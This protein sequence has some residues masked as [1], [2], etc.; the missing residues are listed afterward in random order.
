MY[1]NGGRFPADDSGVVTAG[2]PRSEAAGLMILLHGRGSSPEDILSIVPWLDRQDLTFLV[3]RAP[4]NEWYPESFLAPLERNEPA[5]SAA[6]GLLERLTEEATE[7][8]VQ[9]GRIFLLG[10]SQGACLVLEYAALT[11]RRFG[12]VFGLSGG[13]IG[14]PGTVWGG[15]REDRPLGGTPVLL[16]CSERD[17]YI[18][19]GRV[20][21]TGEI[22]SALGADVTLRLYPG[23]DH[24]VTEDELIQINRIM[25]QSL[26]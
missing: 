22:L 26:S 4:G 17:P 7:S 1:R 10:F 3:P 5:L 16:G 18:P 15:N 24:T 11:P 12:A 14:P 13:L 6:L 2:V 9:S 19:L 21:K 8:G 23:G 20:E 25:R